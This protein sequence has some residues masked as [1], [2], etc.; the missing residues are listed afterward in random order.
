MYKCVTC[1]RCLWGWHL[2]TDGS[3]AVI[4]GGVV[5]V[6]ARTKFDHPEDPVSMCLGTLQTG[7]RRRERSFVEQDDQMT[8]GIFL[9]FC[10][11]TC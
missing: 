11:K 4:S 9:S 2:F 1:R 3:T 8:L 6:N 5:F 7:A 10:S